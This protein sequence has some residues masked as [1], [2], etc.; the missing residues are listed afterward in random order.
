MLSTLVLAEFVSQEIKQFDIMLNRYMRRSMF[1]LV[2]LS[3]YIAEQARELV[4]KYRDYRLKGSD[5]VHL[6]SALYAQANFFFTY[7]GVF[8]R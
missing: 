7:D 6:A 4:R 5:A 3:R 2:P 8:L 1:I